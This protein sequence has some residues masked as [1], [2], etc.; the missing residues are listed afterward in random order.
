MTRCHLL[1]SERLQ[2]K[3]EDPSR[4]EGGCNRNSFALITS[5][6]YLLLPTPSYFLPS[7]TF[8]HGLASHIGIHLLWTRIR[9]P[10]SPRN[11][12]TN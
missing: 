1:E 9:L 2:D 8:E 11:L 7:T 3:V 5:F 12:T 10:L 6:T 4:L